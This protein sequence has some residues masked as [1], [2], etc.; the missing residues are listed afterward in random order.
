MAVEAARAAIVQYWLW[1]GLTR[2][3]FDS[4]DDQAAILTRAIGGR[5][6]L[7]PCRSNRSIETNCSAGALPSAPFFGCLPE[8]MLFLLAS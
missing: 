8:A 3:D 5:P 1:V 2:P 6:E 7:R 4:Y